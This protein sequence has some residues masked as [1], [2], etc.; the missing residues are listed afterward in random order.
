MAKLVENIGS[1]DRGWNGGRWWWWWGGCWVW[2]VW[3]YARAAH[4]AAVR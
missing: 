2:G 3:Q 1:S 4:A